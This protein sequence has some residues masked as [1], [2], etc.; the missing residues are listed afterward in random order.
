GAWSSSGSGTFSPDSLTLNA[1]YIPSAS[2]TSIGNIVLTLISTNYGNCNPVSDSMVVTI[3]SQP[4]V[5]AGNNMFVCNDNNVNLNGTVTN[6]SGTG[7]WTTNGTGT[8]N[9]NDSSLIATYIPSSSD[10]TIGTIVMTLTSTN[11]GGCLAISDSITVNFTPRPL[12]N[13]GNDFSVC[14]NDSALLAGVVTGSSTTGYWS[15][16]GNGNFS[17]DSSNLNAYYIP[18]SADISNG[19]V[20]IVL[21]SSNACPVKDTVTVSFILAPTVDAGNNIN[22]CAGQDT[23]NL[24][25]SVSGTTN[26]GIWTTNGT[27]IFIPNDS[28]LNAT[29]QLSSAD[30]ANGNIMLI[31]TSTNAIGCL[32]VSDT[33]QINVVFP[34]TFDAGS[35]IITC[36]NN[37]P[38]LQ[39]VVS[40]GTSYWTTN[41]DGSFAPDSSDLNAT[42]ILGNNDTISAFVTIYLNINN[43]CGLYSDMLNI[44]VTPAPFVDAGQDIVTCSNTLQIQLNG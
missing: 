2:D 27:G 39:G 4:I 31:L 12:V 20:D 16:T 42:Y 38:V 36:A 41:G 25:G 8:F 11:N 40:S 24:N 30:S 1:T 13:A 14:S 33:L 10:T 44:T 34:P 37:N 9:P 7:I 21:T 22:I 17:P 18:D 15:S 35:D 29:Y 23:V 19:F 6:G 28:T 32:N 26:T 43:A 5:N 3:T